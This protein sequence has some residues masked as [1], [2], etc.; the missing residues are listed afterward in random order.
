MTPE[1]QV[2]STSMPRALVIGA[3]PEA[4]LGV[5]PMFDS[6]RLRVDFLDRDDTPYIDDSP[7][8]SRSRGDVFRARR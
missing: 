4:L 3:G 7:P 6:G 5:E 2:Q 8:A 1:P